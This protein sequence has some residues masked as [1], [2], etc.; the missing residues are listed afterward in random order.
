MVNDDLED[1]MEREKHLDSVHQKMKAIIVTSA[2]LFQEFHTIIWLPIL[3]G[4]AGIESMKFELTGG[5]TQYLKVCN[6]GLI[7]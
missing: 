4:G 6:E 7:L 2:S 3:S 5:H 1:Y